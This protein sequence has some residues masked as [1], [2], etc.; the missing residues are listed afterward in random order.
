MNMRN[1]F[2]SVIGTFG[3]G[4]IYAASGFSQILPTVAMKKYVNLAG[5]VLLLIANHYSQQKSDNNE[6]A[7]DSNDEEK[8][9][10]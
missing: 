8:E 3:A 2:Y 6:P 4:M 5:C 7:S 9:D 1:K 10:K